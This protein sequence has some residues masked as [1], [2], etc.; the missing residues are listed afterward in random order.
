MWVVD[1]EDETAVVGRFADSVGVAVLHGSLDAPFFDRLAVTL[2]TLAGGDGQFSAVVVRASKVPSSMPG[3]LREKAKNVLSKHSSRLTGFGYVL[4]GSGLKAKMVRGAM[5]AVLSTVSFP[6]KTF[7]DA[8]SAVRWLVGL[9]G[10]SAEVRASEAALLR[11]IE[12]L[13]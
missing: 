6:A 1:S 7:A 12:E 11:T 2:D 4:G 9:S 8:P 3:P 10:Q 5:N 13:S